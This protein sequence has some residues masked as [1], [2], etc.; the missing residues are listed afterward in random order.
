MFDANGGGDWYVRKVMMYIFRYVFASSINI[1]CLPNLPVSCCQLCHP[2]TTNESRFSL[3]CAKLTK[4]NEASYRSNLLPVSV[5][6]IWLMDAITGPAMGQ[7]GDF[8]VKMRS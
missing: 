4:V 6:F 5:D 3:Y 2:V 7:S 1:G 8:E